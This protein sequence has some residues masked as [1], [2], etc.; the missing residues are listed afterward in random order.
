MRFVVSRRL[1]KP[2]SVAPLRT[3]LDVHPATRFK[4]DP[5][6]EWTEEIVAELAE[7]DAVEVLDL[8][9]AYRGTAVDQPPD[10]RLYRLVAEAFP[11][12][13]LEDPDL[14]DPG[15]AE[16][17]EPHHERVSWDAVIHSV[18][19]IE[20]LPFPPRWLNIKPSRF[21]SCS[22]L[23]DTYDYCDAHGITMYGGG[24]FELSVGRGQIQTL[25]SLFHADGPND[26]A[27]LGYDGEAVEPGTPASPLAAERLNHG[28][29]LG[30]R[31]TQAQ[32]GVPCKALRM[33]VHRRVDPSERFR[34]RR[35]RARRRKRLRRA[36]LATAM[37]ALA[38]GIVLGASFFTRGGAA[39]APVAAKHTIA[40][41]K[42]KPRVP[43]EIRGVHMTMGL[44]S[45]E[46]KLGEYLA[47][48]AYGL[49]TLEL[50]VKDE[51]GSVGFSSKELPQL[52][53][54]VGAASLHYDGRAAATAAEEAGVYLIGRV[55][56]FADPT[57]APGAVAS[58]RCSGPMARSGT[59]RRGS[60]G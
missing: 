11:Q 12:A 31:C 55:V 39:E 52:A 38:A 28:L 34:E 29:S 53:H 21:G 50:D 54:D 40:V 7:L 30:R 23:F 20:G 17:L 26:V 6:S 60:P 32:L 45:I 4:L 19:E 49:N 1:P 35:Q 16:A 57:L 33:Y 46:G 41:T 15:T 18:D 58:S 59:T 36:G 3:I 24:Q 25:A 2:P 5:T 56:A 42:A 27:P 37:L 8:K 51:N 22:A 44:A 14:V 48:R 10:P 13:V 43:S 9:G 47:L